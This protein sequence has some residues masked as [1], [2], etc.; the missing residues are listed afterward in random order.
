VHPWLAA[1]AHGNKQTKEVYILLTELIFE[2]HLILTTRTDPPFPA[3]PTL[4]SPHNHKGLILVMDTKC[5]IAEVGTT[6]SYTI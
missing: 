2:F 1:D 6:V 5:V 4:P 3:E